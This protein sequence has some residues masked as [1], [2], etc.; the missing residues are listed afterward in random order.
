MDRNFYTEA[1]VLKTRRMGDFHKSVIILS[2][3][4]G[5]INAIVHGAYKGKS[6]MSSITDPFCITGFELYHNPARDL[7]KVTGCRPVELNYNI[8]ENLNAHYNASFWAEV[9]LKSYASGADFE[10]VFSVFTEAL[11][12]LNRNTESALVIT[13][14]FLYRFLL[15]S[16][17][18][19]DFSSCAHCGRDDAGIDLYFSSAEGCFLCARCSSGGQPVIRADSAYYLESSASLA[20]DEAVKKRLD[21]Q[22]GKEIRNTL[23]AVLKSIIEVPLKTLDYIDYGME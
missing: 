1:V 5:I 13:L 20:L 11:A 3:E 7:W 10:A 22:A 17:F 21:L 14:H 4:K 16:G 19:T 12:C 8:R 6:S 15:G 18:M 9:I 23:L 2:P